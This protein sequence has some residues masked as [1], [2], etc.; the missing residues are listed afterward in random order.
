MTDGPIFFWEGGKTCRSEW[1][2][3]SQ[4][5]ES[6]FHTGDKSIIYNTAEQYMMHQK[7]LLFSDSEIAAEILAAKTPREQKALGRQVRNFDG[8]VWNSNRLR[9]VTQG[10]YHKFVHSLVEDENLK[11][12][13]L[14]TGDTELIEASPTDRIWGIGFDSKNAERNRSRWGLNL[15]GKALM[16]ARKKIREEEG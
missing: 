8:K 16:E 10:S 4:W 15:L 5:Y 3:L 14:A 6:P 12:K 2:F 7:A 11:E 1:K 13:L 9:I